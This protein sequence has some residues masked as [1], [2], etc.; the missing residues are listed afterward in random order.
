MG[1]VQ[2]SHL[3]WSLPG[4]RTL[5]DDVSFRVGAGEHV[6]LVGANGAGKTTIMR[7]LAGTETGATGTISVQGSLGV[8]TQLVGSLGDDT[9]VREL[10]LS[11]ASPTIREAAARVARAETLMADGGDGMKYAAALER[12]ESAGGYDVEVLW[13]ECAHRVVE[14][15]WRELE[16]RPMSTFSRG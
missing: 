11:M 10:Y 5:L 3:G 14:L 6:A 1:S 4:G 15:S 8:M 13:E 7:L 16:D 12:W 9:T 2:V